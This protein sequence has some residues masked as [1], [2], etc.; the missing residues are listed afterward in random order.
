MTAMPARL[1]TTAGESDDAAGIEQSWTDADIFAV[2]FD[3]HAVAV[4]RFLA[5][6][7]GGQLADDLTGQ[8]MLVAFDQRRRFDPNG[9][10]VLHSG[11]VGV[12]DHRAACAERRTARTEGRSLP[13]RATVPGVEYVDDTTDAAGRHGIGVARSVNN[14]GDRSILIFDRTT[15]QVMGRAGEVHDGR[16]SSEAVLATGL[17]EKAGQTP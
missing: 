10:E 14:A 1:A 11:P 13:C 5:R 9:S 3:R 17:V 6:R 16:T 12:P 2:I 4:Y 15:Y 8:T 7:V